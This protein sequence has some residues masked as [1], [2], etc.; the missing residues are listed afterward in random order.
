MNRVFQTAGKE[1]GL[2]I[3]RVEDFELNL[4][5]KSYH[6][7]FYNGDC[8]LV[9][10]TK[11]SGNSL[12]YDLHYWIG[13]QSSQDE[14]GAAAALTTQLDDYLRG[15]PT[16][17]RECEG[18][19]SKHFRGYFKGSLI[20]KEG[21][22]KSGFNHVETNH[23]AIRRLLHVKG[24]KH[25][26]AREV[27]MTWNSVNDG[28]VFI[29]DVGQG[30]I[31][32]NAPKSN[33]QEKLKAA[34]LARNIRDRERGGRIPIV[35]IDAGEEADYPQCQEI[36]FKLL[37]AKPAK[38]HKARPDDAVDRRAASEIKL[39]H[40]SSTSGQLVVTEIGERPLVQKMLDHNDC[41]CVDLGG[42]QIFVWKGRGATA[43]EKSGVL[44]KATKYIEARG[45]AKTTPLEI[46]NDGS[47]SALFRSVFQTWK[48]PYA[49]SSPQAPSPKSYSSSNIAKVKATKFDVESMHEK[50]GVAAKHRM[51]DDGTGEVNV[52]R[53][54]NN[55]LVEVADNQR[56]IFFGG[57][58]YIVFYTYMMGSVPNYL[59]YIWQ[60][61]HA[62]QDEVTASAYLAVVLDRQ[63]NDEP[64]QILV[65][66][67]KEPLHFMAMF[68][69][70]MLVYEGGTGRNQVEA[71]NAPVQ[72]F[73]V[74]GTEEWST[75]AFEVSPTAAS[76]NSNDVF[77]LLSKRTSSAFLWFGRGCSGDEREMGRLVA[78]RL[79]GDIEVEIIAEGQETPQFWA[80]L[81]GQAEYASGKEFQDDSC[82]EPRLFE[83]SNASGTFIC[84]EVFAFSQADLDTED[85]MLLDTWSQ[86]FI[87]VGSGALK[88]EKE[89]ALVAAYEYLN[90]DPAGRDLATN[91]VLV[92]QGREPPTFTGW[93]MA[94]DPNMWSQ[95]KSYEEIKAEMG[96][97]DLFRSITLEDLSNPEASEKVEVLDGAATRFLPYEEL[98]SINPDEAF[99]VDIT[100]KEAHLTDDDF[101]AVFRMT[102]VEFKLLPKWKQ[103]NLKKQARLF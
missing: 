78:H 50:P 52:Y 94:W 4:V 14:Q 100:A 58:C 95:G 55:S 60:G 9:L 12:T 21:G 89:Q 97:D 73:Q 57:D 87:W 80:E 35:T 37:G 24:K 59:I 15:L 103:D 31:Q 25:V 63:F 41:Y 88:E 67:G 40:V 70:K 98:V 101:V 90:T 11:R 28:D 16:Q 64:T 91:I 82:F 18:A 79:T 34:E 72:F 22:V 36:I 10:C 43:E 71:Y 54:E 45:Y 56:G 19:E 38:L 27:P 29:L 99:G 23:Y 20:V 17:H 48:D 39:Y 66:M 2:Q 3:W 65:T 42:Q 84:D 6:G 92:K 8:Y 46:V 61:R 102:K 81:G 76:L 49:V 53:V 5:G 32:W 69:G 74:R 13:S 44:A 86:V 1:P 77:V 83:C 51:V 68:K 30:L 85:V 96:S 62:G 33:R 93:F 7:S 47:E 75:K 26:H